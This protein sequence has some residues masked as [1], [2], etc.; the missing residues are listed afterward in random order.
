MANG[1]RRRG[2][3][4]AMRLLGLGYGLSAEQNPIDGN[5]LTSHHLPVSVN[6]GFFQFE[7][8]GLS[9]GLFNRGVDFTT[10]RRT[11]SRV[12]SHW[13]EIL[14][15]NISRALVPSLTNCQGGRKKM[16]VPNIDVGQ[17]RVVH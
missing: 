9:F 6:L 2:L 1:R 16:G 3:V 5:F 13:C 4:F 7:G 12:V 15:Y 8:L 10:L 14:C 11:L 17:Q